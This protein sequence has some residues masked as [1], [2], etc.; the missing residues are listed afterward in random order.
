MSPALIARLRAKVLPPTSNPPLTVVVPTTTEEC[1]RCGR[2]KSPPNIKFNGP[3]DLAKIDQA[4]EN[5]WL[6]TEE[7]GIVRNIAGLKDPRINK[8]VLIELGLESQ[9]YRKVIAY[10]IKKLWDGM[11]EGIGPNWICLE[12]DWCCPKCAKLEEV[13]QAAMGLDTLATKLDDETELEEV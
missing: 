1:V 11:V 6:S 3:I 12:D 13:G 9:D 4:T 2:S 10:L 5:F 7:Y 8:K